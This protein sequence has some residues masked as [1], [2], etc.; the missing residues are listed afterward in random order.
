MDI[1]L[2]IS[3]FVFNHHQLERNLDIFKI[4]VLEEMFYVKKVGAES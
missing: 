4:R 3:N 2:R 1:E